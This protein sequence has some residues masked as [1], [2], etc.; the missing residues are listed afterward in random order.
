[1]AGDRCYQQPFIFSDGS[2]E[3]TVIWESNVV[4]NVTEK[5]PKKVI[6]GVEEIGQPYYDAVPQNSGVTI[7]GKMSDAQIRADRTQ[8]SREHFKKE[9]WGTIPK[10]EKALF[11]DRKDL[12]M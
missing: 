7:L 4:N 6:N 1:M 3:N 12:K 5:F 10:S 9:V 2:I 11:R 8:R